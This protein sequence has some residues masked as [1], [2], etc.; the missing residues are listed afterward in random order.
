MKK[1]FLTFVAL[2]LTFTF[3]AQQKKVDTLR[4]DEIIVVKPYTPKISDA[5]KIKD[6]PSIKKTGTQKDTV[7]YNFFTFPVVVSL[8][9]VSL[10]LTYGETSKSIPAFLK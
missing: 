1:T 3:Y 7:E 8:I 4:T 5:F 9:W 6:S 2:L 10:I